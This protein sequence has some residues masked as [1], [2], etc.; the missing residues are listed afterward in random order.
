MSDSEIWWDPA[1][2]RTADLI[3]GLGG[4]ASLQTPISQVLPERRVKLRSL[5]A[6]ISG[7]V[8][9]LA[10]PEHSE[11]GKR[12]H[13][14]VGVLKVGKAAQLADEVRNYDTWVLPHLEDR[15]S[16]PSLLAPAELRDLTEEFGSSIA[17]IYYGRVGETT[18][19][20]R[21]NSLLT[22]G[23][24]ATL[25]QLLDHLLTTLTPW[26]EVAD[27]DMQHQL[28]S[29]GVYSFGADPFD[30]FEEL[31]AR[32]NK[33]FANPTDAIPR[34]T[35]PKVRDF[36]IPDSLDS[37][38]MIMAVTHG[39]LHTDNV[40]IGEHDSI[41]LIDFGGTGYGHFLRDLT[42]LEAH[43]LLRVLPPD[44]NELE[45]M[46]R[47]YLR[48]ILPLY[49]TESFTASQIQADASPVQFLVYT[50]HQYAFRSL[51]R[52]NPGYIHQYIFGV[53]RHAIRISTREDESLDD[54]H[55]WT[56]ARMSVMLASTLE[57]RHRRLRHNDSAPNLL[58]NHGAISTVHPMPVA[59]ICNDAAWGRLADTILASR[60]VDFIGIMPLPL[61]SAIFQR[62][63]LRESA[64]QTS[65]DVRYVTRP[66]S[67]IYEGFTSPNGRRLWLAWG[68]ALTGTR[69]MARRASAFA[70]TGT[71]FHR[72]ASTSDA[73]SE[74]CIVRCR[75]SADQS[76]RRIIFVIT[77]ISQSDI[78]E[79]FYIQTEL[80]DVDSEMEDWI[81]STIVNSAPI[82]IR[83]VDCRAVESVPEV[84][85]TTFTPLNI[86]RL[87]PYGA[88][89]Q[90]TAYLRPI[91]ITI[92]RARGRHGRSVILKMRSALT[93]NDD[94]G[95]LSFLSGRILEE[96]LAAALS[97]A[98]ELMA[99]HEGAL[100][101]L[102]VAAGEPSPFVVPKEAFIGAAKRDVLVTTGLDLDK[103][104]FRFRGMQILNREDNGLQLGFTVLT[105]DLERIEVLQARQTSPTLKEVSITELY[106]T[107]LPM[108]RFLTHRK[109]WLM[110]RCLGGGD[111]E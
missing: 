31:C 111:E 30:A 98:P 86:L 63:P 52:R 19:G 25:A 23:D 67:S 75:S 57:V 81:S 35:Y 37:E 70:T 74:N 68:A 4:A 105:V 34:D 59:S 28:T 2:R 108:N 103:N 45:D 39:D 107:D 18:L 91:A 60:R 71:G 44:G 100:D 15:N 89:D 42:T 94:Y 99:E 88:T 84:P 29:A 51:M 61:I 38:R 53:L 17:A 36:W 106:T 73:V 95:K 27:V 13:E 101:A 5:T 11:D 54:C 21:L 72:F 50:L 22:A 58:D 43:L 78:T 7:A 12:V 85:S 110:S 62:W 79:S 96:D 40:L 47:A 104:R 83:E 56:A 20:D 10:Y 102:W 48:G 90:R 49:T 9:F 87:S 24:T 41:A 69:N 109:E 16:F 8:V 76:G 6:G 66:Q 77:R 46:H 14:A 92:L 32:L 33:Q 55:R 3:A 93:D 26:Q 97:I 65:P 80:A 82:I 1:D 64:R